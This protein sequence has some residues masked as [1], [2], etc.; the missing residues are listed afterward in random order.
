MKGRIEGRGAGSESVDVSVMPGASFDLPGVE[1]LNQTIMGIPLTKLEPYEGRMIDGILGYDLISRFVLEI[2]YAKSVI[3][4]Y[5]P[6][7]YS[8]SGKGERLPLVLEGNI[9]QVTATVSVAGK[10]PVKAK[11]TIDTGARTALNLSSPFC[12]EQG[13]PGAIETLSGGHGA[14][15]GGE[16]QQVIGRVSTLQLGSFELRDVVAGFSLDEGG[17]LAS[18][19]TAGLIGGD[20]LKRFTVIFDYS[21]S[22]MILEPNAALNAPFEYDM[23]GAFLLAQAPDF[24]RFVVH[25]LIE[26]APAKAAGLKE[27]DIIVSIDGRPAADYTLEQVRGLF[28]DEGRE[29]VLGIEEGDEVRSVKLKL[30]RLI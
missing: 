5:E 10:P 2:D 20:I 7:T 12:A 24:E 16:T 18:E 19:E 3:H 27:G 26:G 8:Y 14:G 11:F 28:R 4:L 29:C 1:L 13:F 15:I 22:E 9:P 17:A 30:K 6:A 21:R 25:R 23:F